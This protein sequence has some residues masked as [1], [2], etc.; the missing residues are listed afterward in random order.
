LQLG[1]ILAGCTLKKTVL[2]FKRL[3]LSAG[4]EYYLMS[5]GIEY[6]LMSAGIRLSTA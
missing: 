5:A 2:P 4:I 1:S 6:Y 3:H